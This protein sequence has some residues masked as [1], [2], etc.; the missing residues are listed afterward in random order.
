VTR[1]TAQLDSKKMVRS[2][3]MLTEAREQ[4]LVGDACV[5]LIFNAL[6]LNDDAHGRYA[7]TEGGARLGMAAPDGMPSRPIRH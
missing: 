7:D 4:L 6:R 2:S 3:P 1:P 5:E